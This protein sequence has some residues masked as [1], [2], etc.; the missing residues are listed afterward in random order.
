MVDKKVKA[1]SGG[2]FIEAR[3]N[4]E[5]YFQDTKNRGKI[6]VNAGRLSKEDYYKK[7]RKVGIETGVISPDEF[8]GGAPEWLEPALEIGL[9]IT[10]YVVGAAQG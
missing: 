2:E 9:G 8:P 3:R 4:A 5:A 6:L 1:P 10:G 7:I